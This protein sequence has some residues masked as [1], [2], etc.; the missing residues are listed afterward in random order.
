MAT[1]RFAEVVKSYGATRVVDHI[2]LTV[3][4]GELFF[5]LGP[6]GC[7]KTTLLRMVAGFIDP[8]EGEIYL[9]DRPLKGVPPRLRDTA[10]VFQNYALWPHRSVAGNVAYGLEVRGWSRRQIAEAV[11]KA[12]RMVR[13]EGLADRRPMQLSGGQQQRV[14]LARALVVQPKVLLLDEPLSN[15]DARLRVEMREEIR[16]I[17]RETG[18][19]MIY[20]THDQKEAMSLADRIA[21]MNQG[22]IVQ[23]G[24]PR[25]IYA[26]PANRFVADFMGE[27]NF[28]PGVVRE[29][30]AN[31]CYRVDTPLGSLVGTPAD[32]D[33]RLN[34]RVVCCIRPEAIISDA[35]HG[36]PNVLTVR[37]DQVS[38]LGETVAA[39]LR[40][41]EQ[42]LVAVSLFNGLHDW[43]PGSEVTVTV[44]EHQVIIL[45]E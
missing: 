1:I 7:G 33:L 5:L 32:N 8:D 14:A 40:A 2:T 19:T 26:R 6:S 3:A 9:D 34:T 38:F 39:K 43:R 30:S 36:A 20:V 22:R 42:T 44:P 23:V 15:L 29:A 31:G 10:L 37:V 4:D 25:E 11:D 18:L 13:L 12:L 41:G 28:V 16:R 17:H 21:V 35:R 27:S 24:K 45:P